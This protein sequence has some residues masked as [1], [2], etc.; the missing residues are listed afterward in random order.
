MMLT[1]AKTTTRS[2]LTRRGMSFGGAFRKAPFSA[3]AAPPD[4]GKSSQFMIVINNEDY[5]AETAV[6]NKMTELS[7][8]SNVNMMT[9]VGGADTSLV[10]LMHP[11]VESLTALD[12]R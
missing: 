12:M 2:I 5:H 3:A 7:E 11:K 6:L 8:T 4:P 9:V 1:T 10:S